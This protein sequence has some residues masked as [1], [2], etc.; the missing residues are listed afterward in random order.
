MSG[1]LQAFGRFPWARPSAMACMRR[2]RKNGARCTAMEARAIQLLTRALCSCFP[3]LSPC[4][5]HL[6]AQLSYVALKFGCRAPK[7]EKGMGMTTRSL[8]AA[9]SFLALRS[10]RLVAPSHSPP[11]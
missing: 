8:P 11:G 1:D 9:T 2:T 4:D 7:D 10:L 6:E 5:A 3:L